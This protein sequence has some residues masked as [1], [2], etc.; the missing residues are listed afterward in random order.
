ME[1]F[2]KNPK[3]LTTKLLENYDW[4]YIELPATVNT[5]KLMSWYEE[6]VANNMHSALSFQQI[7]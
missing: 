7:K 6:V 2:M 3:G 5:E 4:D 1:R